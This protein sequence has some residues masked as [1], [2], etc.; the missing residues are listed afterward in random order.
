VRRGEELADVCGRL[1]ITSTELLVYVAT[2]LVS[3]V[4]IPLH[5]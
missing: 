5:M 1:V 3:S 2:V 4:N